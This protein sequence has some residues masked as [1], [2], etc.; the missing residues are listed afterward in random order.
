M[1][2]QSA[3]L[4]ATLDEMRDGMMRS[5]MANT[6]SENASMRP[7]AFSRPTDPPPM[8]IPQPSLE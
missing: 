6:P 2:G 1:K 4:V 7:V 5:V 8:L 3:E